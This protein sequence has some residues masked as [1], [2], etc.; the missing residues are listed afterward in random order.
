QIIS[1][2]S[3]DSTPQKGDLVKAHYTGTLLDGS[4]FDSSRDRGDPFSFTIG[5]GQVIA[6]W[7]E[8]F[9]TM[10]KGERA[11]LT[12]TAENAYG[13]RGAGEK[14]PPGAT[15]RFDVELIDFGNKAKS[16]L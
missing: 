14:I 16:E 6:C 1:P 12:C 11:L 13:D 7:D 15:L 2:G 5:Q 3:G 9:L 10:K 8:A 4:K